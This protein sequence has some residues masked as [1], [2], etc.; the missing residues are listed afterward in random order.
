MRICY[1]D[2]YVRDSCVLQLYIKTC[3]WARENSSC[4]RLSLTSGALSLVPGCEAAVAFVLSS[5]A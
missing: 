4:A 1:G 5:Q 2:V 3:C